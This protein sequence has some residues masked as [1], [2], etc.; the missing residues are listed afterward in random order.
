MVLVEAMACGVPCVAFEC[1]CG[2]RDLIDPEKDGLLVPPG[3]TGR[4]AEAVIRMIEHPELRRAMGAAARK[5]A[6]RYGLD[7]IARSWMDLFHALKN[8]EN[9]NLA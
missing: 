5:K 6:G 9:T 7:A 8:S 2:P 4:L 1:P 3:D